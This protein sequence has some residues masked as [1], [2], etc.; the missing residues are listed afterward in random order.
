[1]RDT[2]I[3]VLNRFRIKYK[4]IFSILPFVVLCYIIIFCSIHFLFYNVT[5]SI[6][7]KQAEQNIAEK[8]ERF[9]SYLDTLCLLTDKMLY[10]PSMQKDLQQKQAGMPAKEYKILKNDILGLVYNYLTAYGLSPNDVNI[11]KVFI[12]NAYGEVVVN[13]AL[14][15]YTLDKIY[16]VINK[17]EAPSEKLHGKIYLEYESPN[18][19]YLVRTIYK[20]DIDNCDQKIG[21][22]VIDLNLK[23]FS[24]QINSSNYDNNIAFALIDNKNNVVV[25]A[26]NLTNKQCSTLFMHS[27]AI[28]DGVSYRGI[29]HNS[30]YGGYKIMGMINETGLYKE[31]YEVLGMVIILILLSITII[32]IAIIFSSNTISD[33]FKQFICKLRNTDCF[34]EHA[35]ILTDSN[36]EFKE[37]SDVYNEMIIRVD[38]LT[39]AVIE[40]EISVKNA[41]IREFQAQI[42]PH[43]LYNTLDCINGLI[44]MDK[45]KEAKK[46][47]TAL[48][49]I[50]RM[51]IK[52]P[53]FI[54]IR[55]EM[56]YINQYIFIHKMRYQNKILFLVDIQENIMDYFIPKL[57]IQP[58]IENAIIHGV[59]DLLAQGMIA[60]F[61]KEKNNC[62]IFCIKDNGTGM[63]DKI[64]DKINNYRLEL[65]NNHS[66][67]Q[68]SMGILNIQK[69]I[70]LLYGSGYGLTVE[71]PAKGGT[72]V[73]IRLPKIL[74]PEGGM[75]K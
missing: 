39:K 44:G 17:V 7:N 53:N 8:V 46:T 38:N 22:L 5:K 72:S 16:T 63:P 28:L 13:D 55:Q 19:L 42:N 61:G 6:I 52:G 69:R 2:I 64:I 11:K 47:V 30:K 71:R 23:F 51:A 20:G 33:Q 43:F 68:K 74:N 25:N 32:I 14:Y 3:K 26:S 75:Q 41:E 54:T 36:D 70:Q 48:G 60:V 45:P 50:M 67:T 73:T 59:A 40:E 34:N 9:D 66:S 35:L 15:N 57:I 24:D 4:L 56:E 62:I 58:I 27:A 10:N 29:Q 12:Q 1:M 18:D 49:N 37:L 65:N 21:M 31:F